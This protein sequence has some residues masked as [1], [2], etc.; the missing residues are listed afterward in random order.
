MT[1]LTRAKA[2]LR[3]L[4]P[5]YDDQERDEFLRLFPRGG[6]CAEIGVWKGDFS[7]TILQIKRPSELHLV[8]PWLFRPEFPRRWYGG[9]AARSQ[10]DMDAIA[11]NVAARFRGNP[12][13]HLH[14]TGSLAFWRSG[15]QGFDWTYIDGDHSFDAVHADLELAWR[16]TKPLGY[17]CGDDY[18][19][20]AADGFGVKK[21]VTMFAACA[22]VRP[23]IWKS[24]FILQKPQSP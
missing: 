2:A 17:V 11:A 21:A 23:T 4:H 19:D 8:D 24:Q 1:L 22:G 10:A 6:V 3:S 5:R 13:V 7:A 18:Y 16:A 14:R 12:A 20:S 9:A 15:G